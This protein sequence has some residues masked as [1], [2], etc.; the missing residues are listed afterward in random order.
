M[1]AD[2]QAQAQDTGHE[3][4]GIREQDN[5]LPR[6]WLFTLYGAIAFAFAYWLYY[7]SFDVGQGPR[8]VYAEE[9]AAMEAARVAREEKAA[10]EL[11]D[12]VLV[13]MSRDAAVVARGREAY[14]ANCGA[15]HGDKGQG[16]VGPNLTDAYW[17]H[18]ARPLDNMKVI[19]DG[20]LAK[21]MPAWKPVLGMEKVK[22]VVA[23]LVTLRGTNATG[24]KGA[25]GT[26]EQ[27]KAPPNG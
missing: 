18:G 3:Y 1:S 2:G 24:G 23:Y 10:K 16:L 21:G 20:F 25:E 6:W 12:E 19:A 13:T 8:E 22:D 27:G 26:D 17:L 14:A 11:S 9:W 4:D 7:H 5:K 15:C